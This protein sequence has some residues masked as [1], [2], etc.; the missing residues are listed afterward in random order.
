MN[1][2]R[3]LDEEQIELDLRVEKPSENESE[4]MS[5]DKYLWIIKKNILVKLVELLENSDDVRN[6]N[7]LLTDL[8]NREKRATTGIGQGIAIPHVRTISVRK[9]VFALARSKEGI[10]FGS[11][12]GELTHLFFVLVAPSYEEDKYLK[13]YKRLAGLLQFQDFYKD[14]M[15]AE[16][17]G[18][19]IR[20]I[21]MAEN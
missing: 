12:D 2:Y 9:P 20:I 17:A 6:S 7:R 21:R 8:L 11:I 18:E 16:N 15:N 5:S 19:I 14:I 3:L 4:N 10:E 1:I 13:Y